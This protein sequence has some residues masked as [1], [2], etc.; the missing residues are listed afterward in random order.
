[1]DTAEERRSAAD[2]I[3]SA[4]LARRSAAVASA[5]AGSASIVIM[6]SLSLAVIA[7]PFGPEMDSLPPGPEPPEPPEPKK[8]VL[9]A[10]EDLA[11]AD[12]EEPPKKSEPEDLGAEVWGR[13]LLSGSPEPKKSPPEDTGAEDVG[14]GAE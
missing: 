10:P 3:L 12:E 6:A 9:L 2:V 8:S 4:A 7:V 13:G 1:M 5:L 11:G 14:A